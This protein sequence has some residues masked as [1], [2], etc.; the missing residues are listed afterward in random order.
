MRHAIYIFLVFLAASTLAQD[1]DTQTFVKIIHSADETIAVDAGGDEWLY[2]RELGRFIP[3]DEYRERS[4]AAA[5]RTDEDYSAGEVILPPEI[6]CTDVRRGDIVELFKDVEVD[7]DD[8]IEGKIVCGRDV[9]IRGLV[10]G[11]VYSYRTVTV[12]GTGEVRGDVVAREIL[13]DRGSRIL[14]EQ[15]RVILPGGVGV[16]VPKIVTPAPGIPGLVLILLQ[17]FFVVIVIAIAN[18]PINRILTKIGDNI[19]K[20]FLIGLAAWFAIVPL[21][22][23]LLITIVGIPIA[24]LIYPLALLVA[25]ILAFVSAALFV[26]DRLSRLIGWERKSLYIKAILGVAAVGMIKA[27]ADLV[28]TVG[29][30]SVATFFNAIFGI[31]A[32]ITLTLGLGAVVQARFGIKPKPSDPSAGRP[33]PTVKPPPPPSADTPLPT[34]LR[35]PPPPVPPPGPKS[36]DATDRDDLSSK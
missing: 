26:G 22:V 3:V 15:H 35:T 25:L 12:A 36:S 27:F 4:G 6:R 17:V 33:A 8:R 16:G 30:Q 14:G 29:I 11:D 20:S 9:I 2:D 10:I 5:D 7:I 13:S 28:E 1:N 18:Q 31:I 32:V 34:I 23:L 19:L 21:F 24:V